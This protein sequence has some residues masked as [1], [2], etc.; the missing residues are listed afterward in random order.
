[1]FIIFINNV[2]LIISHDDDDDDDYYYYYHFH[3]CHYYEQTV[4]IISNVDMVQDAENQLDGEDDNLTGRKLG[5][6]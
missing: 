6:Y 1:M 3:G 5:A 2:I 4:G